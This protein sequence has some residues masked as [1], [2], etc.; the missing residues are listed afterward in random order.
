M[1]PTGRLGN[2]ELMMLTALL[3]LG[4]NA[5]GVTVSS[6]LEEQTGREVLIARVYATLERLQRRGLVSSR[7]GDPTPER[8]GKAKRYF[9]LTGAGLR[10]ARDARRP[11]MNL[12]KGLAQLKGEQA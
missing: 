9:R 8:G 10:E 1:K 4:E 2:S 5:Y 12:W 3:S 7:L 6:E 11:P